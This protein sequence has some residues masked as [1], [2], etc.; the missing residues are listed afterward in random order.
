M[1]LEPCPVVSP[2]VA[3]GVSAGVEAEVA[4]GVSPEVAHEVAPKEVIGVGVMAIVVVME[5]EV[6][7]AEVVVVV[8]VAAVEEVVVVAAA[9]VGSDG[10]DGRV[11]G[12]IC[13]SG[14][15][16]NGR[17][18]GLDRI[19]LEEAS[20]SLAATIDGSSFSIPVVDNV[21]DIVGCCFTLLL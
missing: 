13:M 10:R 1:G 11:G 7:E 16:S 8:V 14:D 3:A 5:T 2:E 6:V 19:S 17:A 9:D 18:S 4:V 15:D 20:C 12:A 21:L